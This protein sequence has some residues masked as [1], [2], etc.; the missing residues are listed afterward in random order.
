MM[1]GAVREGAGAAG[2]PGQRPALHR[3]V[4]VRVP[5]GAI[6]IA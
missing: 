2:I 6:P 3:V 1:A 4:G 5:S